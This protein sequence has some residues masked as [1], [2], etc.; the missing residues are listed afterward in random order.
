MDK[1][2]LPRQEHLSGAR[3]GEPMEALRLVWDERFTA[4]DFGPTHPMAPIRLELTALLVRDLGLFDLAG[5]HVVGAEP[6]SD[7]ILSTVHDEEYI[8]AV[9]RASADP[10]EL[11]PARGLGTDD[12]P[13]FAGMH[14]ASARIAAGT[15]DI[16]LA[17]WDGQAAHGFNFTGGLHHAMPWGAS[18]FCVY[19]DIAVAIRALLAAGARKVAYV[20]TDV[21]HGDGVERIFWDDDRVLTISLHESGRWLFPGTGFPDDTGGPSAQGSAVNVALPPGTADASWLRAFHS[22]VPPLVRAFEPDV[23]V[24]QHGCDGHVLDPLA[25]LALSLDAMREAQTALH[26]LS[27]Q[28]CDG[29]WIATGGGGYEV[30]DVV[31]RVWSH[32]CAIAAHQPLEPTSAVP[33]SWREYV[34][35]RCGRP[36]PVRMT[37]GGETT[38]RS[39][40][41]G[42]DP[43][44]PVDRA[45]LAARQAV[46]PFHGLDPYFD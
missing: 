25:H 38:Y 21:H 20:D 37:D 15:R 33:D 6:A 7:D 10:R 19:N 9:R 12:V 24:T 3:Y 8:A 34:T 40:S 27:H 28:V 22:V 11:D 42:Y 5:V 31:P 1:A 4:Y 23:I 29:R 26:E 44:D 30:V 45:V 16:A 43:A 13:T 17:V 35:S 36:A 39:W 41:L 14:E 18:G 2:T 46:F 32:L